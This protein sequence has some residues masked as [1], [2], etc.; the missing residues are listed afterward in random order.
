MIANENVEVKR[1]AIYS[2]VNLVT[3]CLLQSTL[4]RRRQSNMMITRS[5]KNE[6]DENFYSI[7]RYNFTWLKEKSLILSLS[8]MKS[9]TSLDASIETMIHCS[10]SI[11]HRQLKMMR[12][13]VHHAIMLSHEA[14]LTFASTLDES[15]TCVS[16]CCAQM[17]N[18]ATASDHLITTIYHASAIIKTRRNRY[19]YQESWV[20]SS[21]QKT[22][23]KQKKQTWQ[24]LQWWRRDE[25]RTLQENEQTSQAC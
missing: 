25:K 4:T 6:K 2:S 5:D 24:T 14:M 9:E 15:T 10:R 11:M 18:A 1:K 3:H 8:K 17:M 19:A 13:W 20:Q 23:R 22:R 7:V 16:H 21:T 12:D